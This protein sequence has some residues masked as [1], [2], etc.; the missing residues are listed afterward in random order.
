MG[1]DCESLPDGLFVYGTLRA[2]GANHR[3]VARTG[4]Q[5]SCRAWVPGRLFHLPREAYPAAVPGLEPDAPPPGPGWIRG[6]FLG[7]EDDGDLEAALLDLDQ[8]EDTEGGL[9]ERRILPCILDSGHRYH[10]WVYLFPLE[11]IPLLEAHA[12]ELPEGDW[13]PYLEDGF[14]GS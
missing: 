1:D 2:G 4:P 3:W 8:V 11:R 6:D 13:A 10:A 5:G 14:V 9:F 7:Y 12:V